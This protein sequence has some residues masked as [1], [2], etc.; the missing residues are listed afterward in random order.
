MLRNLMI[1]RRVML[2]CFFFSLAFF[3]TRSNLLSI[4][5]H[6]HRQIIILYHRFYAHDNLALLTSFIRPW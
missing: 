5:R 6:H 3:I 2:T 4:N 1:H